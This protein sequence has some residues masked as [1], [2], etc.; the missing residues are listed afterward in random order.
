MDFSD[1]MQRLSKPNPFDGIRLRP[2]AT[3]LLLIDMQV[4]AGIE[5]L[6]DEAGEAGVPEQDAAEALADMDARI[7]AATAQAARVLQECRRRGMTIAHTRIHSLTPD[8]RDAGPLHKLHGLVIPEGH[9]YAE[10][11]PGVEP[12]PGEIVIPKTSSSFFTATHIDLI[13][14]NIGIENVVIVGFYTDQCIT[15]AARDA[16][17]IGYYT[18]VVED[19]VNAQTSEFHEQALAH[20]RDLYAGVLTAD[21]LVERLNAS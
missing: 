13:L 17:D 11:L 16:A 12:Q 5:P 21:A 8:C 19:A 10:F 15:T 9:H 14:R 7:K 2:E 4:V 3:A 20:I 1:L 6:M 18:F